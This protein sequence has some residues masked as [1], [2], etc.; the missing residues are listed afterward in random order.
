MKKTVI[1]MLL[2]VALLSAGCGSS[3][4]QPSQTPA[5]TETPVVTE[6]PAEP[7]QEPGTVEAMPSYIA[8]QVTVVE[9]GQEMIQTTTDPENVD[10]FENT[11][12]YMI[13]QDTLVFD[14]QGNMLSIDDLKE[15]DL[16][17][18]YTG[19]YTPAPMIMPPQYQAEIIVIQDPEAEEPVFSCAD[20]FVMTDGMLTGLGN[21]LAL[22][23]DD[24]VTVVDRLGQ[25]CEAELENMD[26]L[27]FYDVSTKSVPA[28]T[29]P[30]KVVVLGTNELALAN[31]NAQ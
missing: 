14:A 22:T 2:I 9:I 5:P 1:P 11:I 30:L 10:N 8:N 18:A 4:A 19:A 3:A 20:T 23:M 28:Q 7:S 26:L 25:T 16:I 17:T 12:N 27:V 21:T 15:G 13:T 29:T 6:A 24:S 31:I